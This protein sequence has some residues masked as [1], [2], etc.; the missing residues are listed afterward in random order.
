MPEVLLAGLIVRVSRWQPGSVD[1][2]AVAL[3]T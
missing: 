3:G 1:L 2:W